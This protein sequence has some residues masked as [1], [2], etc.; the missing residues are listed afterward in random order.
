MHIQMV[1]GNGNRVVAVH[2]SNLVVKHGQRRPPQN[3]LLS[4]V[5]ITYRHLRPQTTSDVQFDPRRT[6]IK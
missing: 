5:W 2:Q 3:K 4:L 6:K 1:D